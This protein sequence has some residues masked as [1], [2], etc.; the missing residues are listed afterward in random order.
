MIGEVAAVE[1]LVKTSGKIQNLAETQG[2]SRELTSEGFQTCLMRYPRSTF[3]SGLLGSRSATRL[4]FDH[5]IV[6]ASII[7]QVAFIY[8]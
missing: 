4:S 5:Y 3:T 2:P 8:T 6:S 7:R 1:P